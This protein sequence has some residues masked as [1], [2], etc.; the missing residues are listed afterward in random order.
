MQSRVR[1]PG[2][3]QIRP[4]RRIRRLVGNEIGLRDK[5]QCLQPFERITHVRRISEPALPER[6]AGFDSQEQVPQPLALPRR[7]FC[8]IKILR[9]LHGGHVSQESQSSQA[10]EEL[11]QVV[12]LIRF[13]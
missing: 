11:D 5:R 6:I 1:I 7:Q 2:K 9:S 12:D 8:S 3:R 10:L 13:Q 4:V